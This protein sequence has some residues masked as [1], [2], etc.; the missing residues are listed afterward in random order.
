VILAL[1]GGGLI[2]SAIATTRVD[3]PAFVYF[4]PPAILTLLVSAAD[5]DAWLLRR[6]LASIAIDQRARLASRGLPVDRTAAEAWLASPPAD[7]AP[8]E[9]AAVLM[10]VGRF[11]EARAALDG[12]D[13]SGPLDRVRTLRLREAVDAALDPTRTIDIDAVADVARELAPG[14]RHYQVLSAAWSQ[15][16]L[17][18]KARRPW[19]KPF[20]RV[21]RANGPFPLPRRTE[22]A[23]AVQQLSA[24]IACLIAG[25]ILVIA[26]AVIH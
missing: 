23:I 11:E 19:I 10:N 14:E 9:R 2:D 5:R 21:A 22:I 12:A 13:P 25:G 18:I 7:A 3:V 17:D 15:A 6:A 4:L 20:L 8:F 1:I 16:A 26:A 24:P